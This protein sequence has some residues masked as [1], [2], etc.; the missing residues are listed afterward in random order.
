MFVRTNS[1]R[2]GRHLGISSFLPAAMKRSFVEGMVAK[3]QTLPTP[4]HED[5]ANRVV[6]HRSSSQVLCKRG[7][8][9]STVWSP[10]DIMTKL[11]QS[12]EGT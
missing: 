2:H 3:N 1:R 8:A 11:S 12:E 7:I 5:H 10:R 9:T 4:D 6:Q